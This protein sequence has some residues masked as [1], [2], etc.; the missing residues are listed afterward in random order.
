MILSKLDNIYRQN[1]IWDMINFTK[2][3][4]IPIIIIIIIKL[5]IYKDNCFLFD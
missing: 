4:F 5:N 3:D 2:L 1:L